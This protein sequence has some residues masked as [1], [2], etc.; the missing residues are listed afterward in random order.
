MQDILI[1][2]TSFIQIRPLP[3]TRL[4]AEAGE[5]FQMPITAVFTS[6]NAI[7]ALAP[8]FK[9]PK[10][11]KVYTI[12]NTTAR[13]ITEVFRI[14]IT[15][16]APNAAV[17]ADRIIEDGIKKV[18]FFCSN[19]RRDE[20]PGKLR[21]AQID[22]EEIVV[23]ETIET[24]APVNRVYDGILFYSPSAVHSFFSV[25]TVTSA[26]QLFAI[27]YTTAETIHHYTGN[28]VRIA[29]KP[30]K[31][32]LVRQMIRHFRNQKPNEA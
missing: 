9:K 12:N 17:L 22:V 14:Y 11:W 18:H 1:E 27:G 31:E 28:A 21:A 15:A 32:E 23:Y 20:L 3:P 19:I 13:L 7:T 4:A 2:E 6:A 29:D 24:P 30:G 16:M 5:L 8:V 10:G 26:T 25:N